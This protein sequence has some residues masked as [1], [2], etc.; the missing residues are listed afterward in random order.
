MTN[1]ELFRA[2][3]TREERRRKKR[4]AKKFWTSVTAVATIVVASAILVEAASRDGKAS[5]EVEVI[6]P[7]AISYY[8]QN[9]PVVTY[10]AVET[11][12]AVVEYLEKNENELIEK[13]LLEQGYLSDDVP[14]SY[15]LQDMARTWCS[16]YGVPYTLVLAVIQQESSFITNAQN[17]SCFGYM[18]VNDI[19]T[20]WLREEIGVTDLKDPAQNLH[21]GIFILG[22]LYAKYGDWNTALIC[23]NHG[24]AG[25]YKYVFSQGI[26]STSYSRSVLDLRE[27]WK[28][29]V[30]DD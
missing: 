15:D 21:S 25:A 12:E 30:S 16:Q 27:E 26:E 4:R 5:Q 8:E 24:E 20:E 11:A 1:E 23:Y 10:L 14:L 19:N 13:A 2:R 9:E 28:L 3:R 7:E 22:D 18:Q 6:T 29:V 17:G